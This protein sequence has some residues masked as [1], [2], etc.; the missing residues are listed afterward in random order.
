MK[1]S[2]FVESTNSAV[3]NHLYKDIDY[4]EVYKCI[5]R[6]AAYYPKFNDW[7]FETVIHGYL[8]GERSIITEYSN[9]IL[10]GVAITKST[11]FEKKLCNLTVS[12]EFV[13]RGYGIKLF[14]K[15]FDTLE[16]DKPFL[17]VSELR[18][19][20][21]DKLFNYFGFEKTSEQF[22]VYQSEVTELFF[23][24]KDIIA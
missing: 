19:P 5:S 6:C 9:G 14:E 4:H 23:N 11:E 1:P 13:N 22:G 10:A 20:E 18:H 3:S 17:T 7:F 12:K 2:F 8:R 15:A 21:F 24:E 16:T